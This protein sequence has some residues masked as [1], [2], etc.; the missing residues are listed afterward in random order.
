MIWFRSQDSP[1]RCWKRREQAV[2]EGMSNNLPLA[3]RLSWP[4]VHTVPQR[5]C[6]EKIYW[7]VEDWHSWRESKDINSISRLNYNELYNLTISAWCPSSFSSHFKNLFFLSNRRNQPPTD[8]ICISIF[9]SMMV[10]PIF[11]GIFNSYLKSRFLLSISHV[12]SLQGIN[13]LYIYP[14]STY[15][16][17]NYLQFLTIHFVS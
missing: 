11:G 3:I 17:Y 15:H 13:T 1:A 8:S 16:D 5:R 2:L 9:S 6:L 7:E 12:F 14:Y 10:M 4:N